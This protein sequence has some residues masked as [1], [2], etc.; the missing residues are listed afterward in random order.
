MIETAGGVQST[1]NRK[2]VGPDYLPAKLLKVILDDD[3]TSLKRFHDRHHRRHFE[4]K[5]GTTYTERRH[6]HNHNT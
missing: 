5:R 1:T 4:W 6:D 3:D 2:A